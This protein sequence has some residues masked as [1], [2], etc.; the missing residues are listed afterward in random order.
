MLK[1]FAPAITAAAITIGL[2]ASASAS[3]V[4][5]LTKFTFNQPIAVPGVTLPAGTYVFK[6]ADPSTERK[7]V[8]ILDADTMQSYA[9][10]QAAPRYRSESGAAAALT[11]V[12]TGPGM[13]AAVHVWWPFGESMGFEF[14]YPE[15]Q[16]AKLTGTPFGSTIDGDGIAAIETATEVEAVEAAAVTEEARPPLELPRAFAAP[17]SAAQNERRSERRRQGRASTDGHPGSAHC[18]DR[19]ADALWRRLRA[20][21]E[22]FL[23]Y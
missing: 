17:M 5:R 8:Q 14:L 21:Q 13:P 22:P 7:I 18:A 10:L 23:G 4:D 19:W 1:A 16:Y 20:R 12:D 9:L 15:E 6:L 11:L 3:P 2:G